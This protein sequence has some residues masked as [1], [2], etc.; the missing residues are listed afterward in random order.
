MLQIQLK[1]SYCMR[2]SPNYDNRKSDEKLSDADINGMFVGNV[3]L[4]HLMKKELKL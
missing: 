4:N 1:L 2:F 3:L